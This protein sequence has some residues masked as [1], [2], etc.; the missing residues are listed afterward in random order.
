MTYLLDVNLLVALAWTTHPHHRQCQEWFGRVG[1]RS[2][3]TCAI[4][5]TAFV[6]IL[7]NPRF[8]QW[9]V[10]PDEA[11]EALRISTL[12]PGHHFWSED[13]PVTQAVEFTQARLAGHQ[14]VTDAY[15]LGLTVHKKGRIATLDRGMKVLVAGSAQERV[16]EL[17]S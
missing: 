5:E 10:T 11:V 7:S 6:R 16:V 8:S 9:A 13:L 12:H 17:V 3:A 15:L 1:S 2:W 4:T 14:Q